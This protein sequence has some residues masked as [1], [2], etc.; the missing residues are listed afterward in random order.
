MRRGGRRRGTLR[1]IVEP[2]NI[3]G[4]AT[5]FEDLLHN[6]RS[7]L[8]HERPVFYN[9]ADLQL[10]LAWRLKLLRPDAAI[11]LEVP[12]V[13][14]D[15]TESRRRL[16]LLVGV[17]GL[18]VALELK[19]PRDVYEWRSPVDPVLY[20]RPS[21]DAAD[22]TVYNVVE[23]L[24][25]TERWI[26]AGAAQLSFVVVLTNIQMLWRPVAGSTALDVEFRFPEGPSYRAC[27]TGAKAAGRN[28]RSPF[29]AAASLIGAITASRKALSEPAPSAM[30]S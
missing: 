10:A 25:R 7:Q 30:S 19:Y 16:D 26:E 11:R 3:G 22:D 18:W 29:A 28:L 24:S 14:A 4:A 12:L 17:D 21:R 23:D 9:E 2:T 5:A 8:A 15:V 27:G 13:E 1:R 6:A 20:R